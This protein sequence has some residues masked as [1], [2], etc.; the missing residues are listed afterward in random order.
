MEW[1]KKISSHNDQVQETSCHPWQVFEADWNYRWSHPTF[2]SK[3]QN[4]IWKRSSN[5][6][7]KSKVLHE[8]DHYSGDHRLI[9]H[10]YRTYIGHSRVA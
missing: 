7:D 5:R 6:K 4:T 8:Y 9:G 3:Q 2:T 1:P 10:I